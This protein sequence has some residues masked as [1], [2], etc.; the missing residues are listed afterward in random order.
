MA[1]EDACLGQT[2]RVSRS[3]T[4]GMVYASSGIHNWSN[5]ND[6]GSNVPSSLTG[7]FGTTSFTFLNPNGPPTWYYLALVEPSPSCA[8]GFRALGG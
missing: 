4:L 3:T 5:P 2:L 6:S 8:S 1:L 7:S